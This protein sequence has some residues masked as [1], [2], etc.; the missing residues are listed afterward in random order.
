MY[1][2]LVRCLE[3]V[4]KQLFVS[5]MW[6]FHLALLR[7]LLI[8]I[9]QISFADTQKMSDRLH[10][11]IFPSTNYLCNSIVSQA[12]DKT[13]WIGFSNIF[14]HNIRFKIISQ[15]HKTKQKHNC[16]QDTLH[17]LCFNRTYLHNRF[18][19]FREFLMKMAVLFLLPKLVGV[20]QRTVMY[21]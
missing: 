9:L 21:S 13:L 12:G 18:Q 19:I 20:L 14:F 10:C 8:H 11:F 6:I 15:G 16:M 7:K 2:V 17:V 3:S 1:G 4:M 5:F